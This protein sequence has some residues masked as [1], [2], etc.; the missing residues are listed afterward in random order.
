VLGRAMEL[1]ADFVDI[2]LKVCHLLNS[3]QTGLGPYG[4]IALFFFPHLQRGIL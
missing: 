1:G 4:H 3:S 2:E